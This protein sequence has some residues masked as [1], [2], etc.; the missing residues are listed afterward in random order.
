MPNGQFDRQQFEYVLRQIGMRPEDYLSNR[1]Q[2]AIRQQIVEAVSDGLKAPDTFL[3]AVALYRGED[4]TAEYI[5]LPKT[6]AEPI[7]EPSDAA[8]S[9]YFE[10]NKPSYAAPE[11]RKIAY[12]TLVP[13]NIADES[14]ITDEQ[15]K[16]D[17]DRNIARFTTPETRTIEQLV[18]PSRDAAQTAL[19]SIKAGAT[20]DSI[21]TA[22]GKTPPTRCSA[23][24]PRTRFQT[25]R[26]PRRR[27][28]CR[29]T[30]SARS[31]TARSARCWCASPRSRR[32]W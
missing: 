1:G 5:V 3:R 26:S 29:R 27:L 21:V 25:R 28:R 20:F 23:P 11:Y 13:E 6:L 32:R 30:R 24:S 16:E 31:S 4:R 22:Q 17:Y 12:I 18:F 9:E 15:V 8:L 19:D 10:A 14:A 2:V 7:E